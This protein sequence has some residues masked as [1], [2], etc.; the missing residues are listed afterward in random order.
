MSDTALQSNDSVYSSQYWLDT[1]VETFS[2][3]TQRHLCRTLE[4][5]QSKLPRTSPNRHLESN[6]N[7]KRWNWEHEKTSQKKTSKK[8]LQIAP[9]I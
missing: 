6:T 7:A 8:N 4:N 5:K 1:V 3:H 2:D 9:V